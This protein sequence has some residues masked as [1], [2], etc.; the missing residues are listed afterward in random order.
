VLQAFAGQHIPEVINLPAEDHSDELAAVDEAIAAWEE[1]AVA[2]E[3][4]DSVI[5]IL[6]GLHRKREAVAALPAEPARRE[7]VMS[8]DLFTARWQSLETDR[9]R[10]DL[11]RGMGMKIYVSKDE[12]GKVRLSLRQKSPGT[13]SK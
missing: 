7:V 9:E 13:K 2:G 10:G 12:R 1:K 8:P 5:R 11:L 4:P 6:D 3:S